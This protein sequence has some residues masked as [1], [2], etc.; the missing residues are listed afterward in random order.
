MIYLSE[1]SDVV[2]VTTAL[3]FHVDGNICVALDA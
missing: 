3:Q 1:A 2:Y